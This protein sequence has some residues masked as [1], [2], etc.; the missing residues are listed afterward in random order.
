[1]KQSTSPNRSHVRGFSIIE[2]LVVLAIIAILVAVAIPPLM[3]YLRLY[4]IRGAAQQ[5]ASE[6]QVARNKAISKNVNLGSV[7]SIRDATSYQYVVEDDLEPQ[8]APNWSTVAAEVFTTLAA[9]NVQAGPVRTLPTGVQFA[10]PAG[11]VVGAGPPNNWGFRFNRLGIWCNPDIANAQ[12]AL[13]GGA[14]A[15]AAYITSDN[16]GSTICLSQPRTGLTRWVSVASGGRIQ[17][18]P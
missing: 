14:P 13:P 3:N 6:I 9:S 7:F 11:C 10:A 16:A 17:V 4:T 15:Y 18:Q 12:C 2:L 8:T 1:M 5:V